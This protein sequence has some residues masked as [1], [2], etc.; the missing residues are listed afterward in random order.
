[1]FLPHI[2]QLTRITSHSKTLIDN[3]FSNYISQDIVS[4]NL[5]ATISDHLPQFLIAPH[6]FS[7]VPNRNT[8]IFEHDWS[9]FSYEEFIL[10]YFSVDWSHT[11]KLQNNNI[12]AS[13]QNVFNSMN[14]ILDKH[15][16]FKRITKYKLKFR[17]KPWIT[18]ALQKS[19]FIKNKIFKNYIEKKDVTQK[20]ELHNIYNL[21]KYKLH[22]YKLHKIYRNLISTLMKRSKQNYYSKYFKGNPTN[23]KNTWKGIKS[24]ISM[25]R[26]SSITPTLLRPTLKNCSFPIT[27]IT[28]TKVT[29]AASKTFFLTLFKLNVTFY[30]IC[31]LHHNCSVIH[32]FIALQYHCVMFPALYSDL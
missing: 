5:T 16:P 31:Y 1:M 25:R 15:A 2:D 22:I 28:K 7:N 12:D 10:G 19:I 13:F 6:I 17:T 32:S 29:W 24:I 18:P 21:H 30:F 4:G 20:N 26:S 23:I 11:L 8:N 27:C 9:K 3:I 14:N